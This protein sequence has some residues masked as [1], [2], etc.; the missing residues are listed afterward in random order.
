MIAIDLIESCDVTKNLIIHTNHVVLTLPEKNFYRFNGNFTVEEGI[1]GPL[2]LIL[3]THRCDMALSD[4]EPFQVFRFTQI[5]QQ[6]LKKGA[7]WAPLVKSFHPTIRCPVVPG[8]YT[9]VDGSLDFSMLNGLPLDGYRWYAYFRVYS[10]EKTP[11]KQVLCI[12]A[13][14]TITV[15]KK[16]TSVPKLK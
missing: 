11:S 6:L 3:T 12:K 15:S 4:C 5:C 7:L 10:L 13:L 9:F 8:N 1:L 16:R 2:T 14:A